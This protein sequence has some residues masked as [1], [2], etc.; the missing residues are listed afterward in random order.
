MF[1]APY[2]AECIT[3]F[4]KKFDHI[5]NHPHLF[6]SNGNNGAGGGGGQCGYYLSTLG[7]SCDHNE[8]CASG[9]WRVIFNDDDNN[10]NKNNINNNI[11]TNN[12]LQNYRQFQTTMLQQS[13]I[14][15]IPGTDVEK[16]DEKHQQMLLVLEQF[17]TNHK[18]LQK[19]TI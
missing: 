17:K 16:G 7:M 1:Y 15:S 6:A 18:N 10:N 3:S 14:C 11:N 8:D 4:D 13:G 2:I 5:T 19:T 9:Y 12:N